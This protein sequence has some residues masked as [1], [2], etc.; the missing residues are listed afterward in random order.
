MQAPD[1]VLEAVEPVDR[2]VDDLII[3]QETIVT[4]YAVQVHDRRLWQLVEQL[5]DSLSPA[6]KSAVLWAEAD[7][8]PWLVRI[9]NLPPTHQASVASYANQ[10]VAIAIMLRL[11]TTLIARTPATI[12][13]A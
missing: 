8:Q 5:A 7:D 1:C 10:L 2:I 6:D 12:G 4:L 13:D 3:Q 11:R 9:D